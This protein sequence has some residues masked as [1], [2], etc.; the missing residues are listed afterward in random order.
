M[1]ALLL[2][3]IIFSP[4][5]WYRSLSTM[6]DS[7]S[8]RSLHSCCWNLKFPSAHCTPCTRS[9]HARTTPRAPDKS[10]LS[11][12]A[13]A[14]AILRAVSIRAFCNA[15]FSFAVT[16]SAGSAAALV[17]VHATSRLHRHAPCTSRYDSTSV[18]MMTSA[19]WAWLSHVGSSTSNS[20]SLPSSDSMSPT[21]TLRA[22]PASSE[23]AYAVCTLLTV[24]PS[25]GRNSRATF[26]AAT[27][28]KPPRASAK[29]VGMASS[30]SM[31]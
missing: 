5:E 14:S 9:R 31:K 11:A 7:A 18:P 6:F 1:W 10:P 17:T 19:R 20:T 8:R 2:A 25:A 24:T 28:S 23:V 15:T 21:A 30:F 29:A 12:A 22:P 4:R 13:R 26:C 27:E 3:H 16:P